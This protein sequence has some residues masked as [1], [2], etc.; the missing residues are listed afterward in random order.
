MERWHCLGRRNYSR[1]FTGNAAGPTRTGL[2][3][4]RVHYGAVSPVDARIPHPATHGNGISNIG[5]LP[6]SPVLDQWRGWRQRP[7]N[8]VLGSGCL[9]HPVMAGRHDSPVQHAV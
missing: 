7:D 1:R 8:R 3:L 2:V 5:H 9:Q 4:R 6:V